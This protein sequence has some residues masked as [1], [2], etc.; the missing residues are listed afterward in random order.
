MKFSPVEYAKSHVPSPGPQ[1][2]YVVG[3]GMGMM[4]NGVFLPIYVLY[5][6]Q[7]AG[8]SYS[9]TALAIAIGGLLGLPLTTFA[10]D[11]ADRLGPRRV[12]L[13]GLAGMAAGMGS[14]VFIHGFWSL[15][16]V[17]LGMNIFAFTYMASEGAL[18]RRIGGDNTVTFRSQVQTIG[19]VGL[20]VGALLS[21]IGISIGTLWAYRAMFLFTAAAY[22]V[23]IF[24]T[25]KIPNYQPLPKPASTEKVKA[26]RFIVFR[27]RPFIAYA[28]VSGALSMATLVD[29]LLLPVWIVVYTR[30]P[31]WTVALVYMLNTAIAILLQ[32]R[33]SR[34]IKS[35]RQGGRALL[36]CGVTLI[37]GYLLM[38]LMPGLPAAPAT[39]LLI[40]GVVVVAIAQIWLISGRFVFEFNLPP[41]HAQGQY[42]GFLN[43][44]TTLSLTV[45]PLVLLGV[46]VG[47]GFAGW[48]GLGAFFLV[49]GLIS[50]AIA[51]WGIR[52]RPPVV[53]PE[54]TVAESDE[55]MA[56]A[57]MDSQ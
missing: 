2:A 52:T 35:M 43:T 10:G 27:D 3:Y 51:A 15:L 47:H 48:I 20:T 11:L 28:L 37:L 14:Y 18:M 54:E 32:M 45:A 17:I 55:I 6:T 36:R 41:A 38:A 46:V 29:N 25:L 26:R 21:G 34:N 39:I 7:I 8:I 22:V 30:A 56:S 5:C 19:N 57:G 13:F 4:A 1:R 23:D 24:I 49:L 42:D 53:T 31:H 16:G 9:S 33:L 50:P 44:V 40:V 12:V